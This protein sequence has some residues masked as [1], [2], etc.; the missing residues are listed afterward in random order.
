MRFQSR[1]MQG[2]VRRAEM[3][4]IICISSFICVHRSRVVKTLLS[5]GKK[6][7]YTIEEMT[8]MKNQLWD[9]NDDV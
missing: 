1:M 4:E 3:N 8:E 7:M 9:K 5:Q 2:I 6:R